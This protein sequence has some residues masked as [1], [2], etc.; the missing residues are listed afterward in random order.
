MQNGPDGGT[1][2]LWARGHFK[3]TI[4]TQARVIQRI[5]KYPDKCSM[6]VSA[7]R[8]LAKKHFRGVMLLLEQSDLLKKVFPDVLYQNPRNESPK[9]SEDDGIIVKRKNNARKEATLEAWGIK[10]GMPIGVHF[11]WIILDDLETKDDVKNPDVVNQVRSSFDL[12]KDLLTVDGSISVV[13]TPYSHEGI[14]I[15]F[16]RDKKRANGESAYQFRKYAATDDGMPNG[17]S[18]FLKP[19]VLDDIR[20]EKG[21]YEFYCQQLIDPTPV[22]VRKFESSML[23]EVDPK[24]IPRNLLKFMAIDPAG[25]DK[26]G[27][28]DS[29]AIGVIGIDL[30]MDDVGASD[31][32]IL[33][34]IISPMREEEAPEEIARMYIR[35]GLIL[36]IGIEKVGQSTAELHVANTL[37]KYGRY[38]SQDNRTLAILRPAGRNKTNRIE[39]AIAFPLYQSKIHISTDISYVY[40]ERLKTEMD[41]FPFGQHDDGLDMI[42]YFYDMIRDYHFHLYMQDDDEDANVIPINYKATANAVCGY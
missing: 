22:G 3:S 18:V 26:N 12:T 38:I 10:E 27:T 20:A 19:E 14:Y 28:G 4:L 25:D 16:I 32:Y 39:K 34:L 5:L 24:K 2:D 35:N 9:W 13:G 8:P 30:H 11:D 42:A 23:I 7:T 6:I 40:R 1:L 29:W 36:Q 37:K 33:D 17:K 21:E 15:P 41:H 31:I